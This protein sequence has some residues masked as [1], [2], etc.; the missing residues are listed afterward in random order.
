MR[1]SIKQSKRDSARNAARSSGSS[2]HQW[3][4]VLSALEKVQIGSKELEQIIK[5]CEHDIKT[6]DANLFKMDAQTDWGESEAEQYKKMLL[7][8]VNEM[9]KYEDPVHAVVSSPC[10]PLSYHFV[11]CTSCTAQAIACLK[12]LRFWAVSLRSVDV[13]SLF[14]LTTCQ[15]GVLLSHNHVL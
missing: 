7:A 8:S 14:L 10:F 4:R 12:R 9:L 15:A 5:S 11:V 13:V 2:R 3:N 6:W 1:R